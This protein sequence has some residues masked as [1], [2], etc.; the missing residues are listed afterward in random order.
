MNYKNITIAG[1]GVLGSQL[2]YQIAY[3]GYNVTIYVNEE[4]AVNDAKNKIAKLNKEYV[5]HVKV[6]ESGKE[7]YNGIAETGKFNAAEC[8]EKV[9]KAF[10]NIKYTTNLAESLQGCD[11]LIESI[12]ELKN[13]KTDFYKQV[14]QVISD[15]TVV[16]TN[17]STLLPSMFAKFMK[18]P[19]KYL[20]LHFANA[21]Y[22]NNTAE[23]MAHAG[24]DKK[25]FDEI[26]E[27][28]NSINMVALPIMAEKSGYLLNSLLVPFLLS[29]L[30]MY[31]NGVSD[32]ES[33]D[34]AWKFG[35]G[36]PR[37]PFEIF[38]VVGLVTALN[39]VEQYQKVP[40]LLNP[41]LSKM[42]LPYNFAGMKQ[43]LEKYI[44]EGKL[45]IQSGEGFYK[46]DK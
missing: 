22:K 32:P 15:N 44:A 25:Y 5:K 13:V 31:A 19:E 42:M 12:P 23:V 21:I 11:L 24:T 34:K 17:S 43:V 39:I 1:G 36:A 38:D 6:M 16:V 8:N 27:F 45:G 28:A 35:T 40:K 10:E 4:S 33:I 26:V 37:G 29:G 20:A 18:H 7:F 30:D 14:S 9:A 3:C 41:L 46:Y 2:A